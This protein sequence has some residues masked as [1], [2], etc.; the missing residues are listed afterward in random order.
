MRRK[1][2]LLFLAALIVAAV[3]PAGASG[4]LIADARE[5]AA[6]GH[7]SDALAL[8]SGHLAMHPSDV[9]AR[10]LYGITLS[11]EG[12]HSEARTALEMAL[13]S[14]PEYIDARLALINVELWSRHPARAEELARLGLLSQPDN[15]DLLLA[16]AR[17]LR[18]LG[19]GRESVDTLDR[20]LLLHPGNRDARRDRDAASDEAYLWTARFQQSHEWFSS[21][22]TPWH[23]YSV[24]LKRDTAAGPILA[25]LSRADR[26]Q[27]R[28]SQAEL[29]WYLRLRHGANIYL[30]IGYSHDS[31]LYPRAR[32]GLELYQALPWASEVSGGYRRL[33]FPSP[34]NLYS[35][36]WSKYAGKW[37]LNGRFYLT[38]ETGSSSVSLQATARRYFGRHGEHLAVVVGRGSSSAGI[39]NAT[40]LAVL[41]AASGYVEIQKL[42]SRRWIFGFRGGAAREDRAG[43]PRAVRGLVDVSA[44]IRF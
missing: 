18:L 29:D 17:A 40:D 37:W 5:L 31:A 23:E 3:G 26:F 30:N 36:S 1:L 21:T 7:R 28:S 15:T 27:K 22:T 43:L 11:W 16:R 42:V 14:N 13:V 39:R 44:A 8:L 20:L 24:E 9:D 35:T 41:K 25:R 6:S 10:L 32:I 19:R 12:R 2:Y 4:D 38:P 33:E 34:V